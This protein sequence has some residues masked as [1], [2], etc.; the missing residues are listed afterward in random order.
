VFGQP[1]SNGTSLLRAKV[2][3]EVFLVFVEET[4]LRSLIGVDD[5]EDFCYRFS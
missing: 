1:S 5:C 3:R 4:E 2:K